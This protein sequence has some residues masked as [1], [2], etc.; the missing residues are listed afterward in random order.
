MFQVIL[1][2]LYTVQ[3]CQQHDTSLLLTPDLLSTGNHCVTQ[4]NQIVLPSQIITEPNTLIIPQNRIITN[5]N[6]YHQVSEQK[7]VALSCNLIHR[8]SLLETPAS[9]VLPSN[10]PV[11]INSDNNFED[12]IPCREPS[13]PGINNKI[14]DNDPN[15]NQLWSEPSD[16]SLIHI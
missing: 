7:K 16:L 4:S 13:L 6:G 2:R 12:D 5:S 11:I 8:D 14:I 15:V 3:N 9:Q 1:K 10:D